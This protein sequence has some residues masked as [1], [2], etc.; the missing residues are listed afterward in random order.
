[1]TRSRDTPHETSGCC[2]LK[3]YGSQITLAVAVQCAAERD[4]SAIAMA[5]PDHR[6][7]EQPPMPAHCHLRQHSW[8][9]VGMENLLLLPCLPWQLPPNMGDTALE[10]GTTRTHTCNYSALI[11]RWNSGPSAASAVRRQRCGS[12]QRR[13]LLQ[14]SCASCQRLRLLS[15]PIRSAG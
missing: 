11:R 9:L 1:M 8:V 4:G 14:S 7:R 2:K 3:R 13:E 15:R 10:T 5:Q 6:G 12:R